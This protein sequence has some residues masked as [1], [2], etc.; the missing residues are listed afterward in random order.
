[1][2]SNKKFILDDNAKV[3]ISTGATVGMLI[4][5]LLAV[6]IGAMI[7]FEVS[8]IDQFETAIETF[9]GYTRYD[10]SAHTGS[11]YTGV[12][13]TVAQTPLNVANINLTAVNNSATEVTD[14]HNG[15]IERNE[16][17][18]KGGVLIYTW[19]NYRTFTIGANATTNFTQ[20]NVNYSTGAVV[21]ETDSVT[22]MAITVF[23]LLPIIAL[24][25][26]AGII[27]FVILN[28]GRRKGGGL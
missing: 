4:S 2:K 13:I 14:M 25:V 28:F 18:R 7:Y 10:E 20:I 6:I 26:V 8:D 19:D 9:T 17:Q 1:M 23:G 11:N 12:T 15:D 21:T 5:L 3:K 16:R 22:P 24:V 27:L